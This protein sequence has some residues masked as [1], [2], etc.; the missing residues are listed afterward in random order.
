[1]R[2]I[3]Q[4][5][6]EVHF[7]AVAVPRQV[8][9]GK[10]HQ[11]HVLGILLGVVAQVLRSLAVGLGI[12]RALGGAGDGVNISLAPLNPA[13]RLGTASE[14]PDPA[15]VEIEQVGTRVDAP[16]RPIEFEVIALIFLDEAAR[17]H[18]L[19]HIA[20]QTVLDA[21]ADVC[22]MFLVSQR[23]G[24]LANR[25]EVVSLYVGLVHGAHHIVEL[26]FAVERHDLQRVIKVVEHNHHLI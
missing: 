5:F 8:V 7:H 15:E 20:T 22:L 1:M 6:V 23:T 2:V 16:Q 12:A 17:K 26:C 19:E 24:R 18:N 4:V 25:M 3:L 21:L 10:V 11:H 9:A 13:M 14:Y